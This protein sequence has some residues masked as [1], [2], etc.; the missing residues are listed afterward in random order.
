MG[1]SV[2][3]LSTIKPTP[4][5]VIALYLFVAC[6]GFAGFCALIFFMISGYFSGDKDE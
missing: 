4:D 1:L 6:G 3:D 2:L 5:I